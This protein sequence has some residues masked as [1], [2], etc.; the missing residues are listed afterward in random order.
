M[1]RDGDNGASGTSVVRVVV[2]DEDRLAQEGLVALL[3]LVSVEAVE[4]LVDARG[5]GSGADVQVAG[6]ALDVIELGP[7]SGLERAF[8]LTSHRSAQDLEGG[9]LEDAHLT[10]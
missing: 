6:S 5:D 10:T 3:D 1:E 9:S 2:R 7:V 4:V 8:R